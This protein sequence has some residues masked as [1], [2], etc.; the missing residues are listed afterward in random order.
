MW[1]EMRD[2]LV[3]CMSSFPGVTFLSS[4]LC[5]QCILALH[6]RLQVLPNSVMES[7][8]IPHYI[9]VTEQLKEVDSNDIIYVCINGHRMNYSWL[10][11]G[12]APSFEGERK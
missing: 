12:Y 7:S 8:F 9:S 6:G 10:L 4:Y 3:R 1:M 5:P 11:G 2:L